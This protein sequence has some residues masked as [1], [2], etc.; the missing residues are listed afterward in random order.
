M[1]RKISEDKDSNFSSSFIFRY[2]PY[3]PLFL[4][5]ILISFGGAWF[6]L[7]LA[8][9]VYE[10][11]ARI[12]IKD[13]K[14]GSE[15]SK[16]LES[17]D[18]ISPKKIIDNEIEVLQS[19]SLLNSVVKNLNLYAPVSAET[20]FNTISAYANSPVIIV[21][22]SNTMKQV[23][24]VYFTA[25]SNSVKFNNKTYPLNE[26]VD[27]PYGR[28]EFKK[29]KYYTT[30]ETNKKLFFSLIN[31]KKVVSSL[32]SRLTVTAAN[33][34]SSIVNISFKDEIPERGEDVV[35]ELIKVYNRSIIDEKNTLA[36]N[37]SQFIDERLARVGED[38]VTIEHKMQAYKADKGA[39]D[40]DTQG[41]LFLENVS[42]NDQKVSEI[43]T[44]LSVLNQVEN[45]VRS[46]DLSSGIVP[47]M[48]G[49]DDPSLTQMVKN[50]FDLQIEAES[51]KKTTGE[52]N[53]LYV[54][55]IDRIEKIRPQILQNVE[56]QKQ[57]LLASKSNIS[58]TNNSY[59]SVL[60]SMPETQR[61]LVDISRDQAQKSSLYAFLE[62]KKEETE[63]S[64][65]SSLFG[66]KVID[67]AESSEYPVSPKKKFVYL[68]ATLLALVTGFGI[69]VGK[70]TLR[71]K[72]MFQK[73]IEN[74]TQLPVIGEITAEKSKNAIVIGNNQKTLI[75]EQFRKLRTTLNYLGIGGNHKR[76][77]ITSAI[78]GEG[79][80]FVAA[81]LAISLSLTGKKVVLLDFDLNNPS[82]AAKL[83]IDSDHVGVTEYLQGTTGPD[84]II[85]PTEIDENLFFISTGKLPKNPS[86]LIM[87]EKAGDLL[88]YLD[89]IFDYIVID[90]APVGPVS[91]A[92]ILSPF[93]DATLYIVRHGFTPKVF[94]ERIDENN[95]LNK[96]TNAAIVFNGVSN[97]GIAHKYGYGYGYGYGYTYD[98][99]KSN[100]LFPAL[101]K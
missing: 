33:K 17:L 62:Q 69:V 27:T 29:N 43:N 64:Y 4:I 72:V 7:K 15:D 56:N 34:L 77:L 9:P 39:V 76:I 3:W 36:R 57:S 35:N 26:W 66:S 8:T 95:R 100:K 98:D 70:E 86:E 45:S 94:I 54:S 92:Y 28:L 74:L 38:L 37:T 52:N 13:E 67:Q 93:C 68:I 11:D 2:L 73:E 81:N 25:N 44:K 61:Q 41:K 80:S 82:L 1:N 18:L 63:L 5:L 12:L 71:S 16:T 65:V 55:Y 79:K 60:Q 59:S 49:V 20:R 50:I 91:D 48:A 21:P 30:D 84:K 89:G 53:P 46:K 6:Y 75:A 19:K 10:T 32:A 78:S 85:R 87:N 40:V 99:R 23:N 101:R 31:P 83:N 51:L 58:T 90:V 14:K 96:L 97:R 47:S 88:N 42:S 22:D 24:K